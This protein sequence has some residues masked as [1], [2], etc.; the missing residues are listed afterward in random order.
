MS[1]SRRPN[2]PQLSREHAS[3]STPFIVAAVVLV[4]I[5]AIVGISLWL[6]HGSGGSSSSASAGA[7]GSTSPTGSTT[8]PTSG[9]P[10]ASVAGCTTPP[11]PPSSPQK[12]SQPP[13]KSLA[14]HTTR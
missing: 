12:F 11:S 1:N 3:T 8:A 7:T 4:C 13:P 10:S 14:E 2:N 6:N 5:G 9:G